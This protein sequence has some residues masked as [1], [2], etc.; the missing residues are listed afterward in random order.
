MTRPDCLGFEGGTKAYDAL[1]RQKAAALFIAVTL[2]KDVL[3]MSGCIRKF[4]FNRQGLADIDSSFEITEPKYGYFELYPLLAKKLRRRVDGMPAIDGRVFRTR[5]YP[6]G[7]R[8][9]DSLVIERRAIV[10]KHIG[11]AIGRPIP[12]YVM[13][14]C[15]DPGIAATVEVTDQ[16]GRIGTATFAR[17]EDR[18]TGE[19]D[20][21][22]S[23]FEPA[24]VIIHRA[25]EEL[26]SCTEQ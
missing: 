4:A 1:H 10:G 6:P 9:D 20:R 5:R 8:G 3:A 7:A 19:I 26:H 12:E 17:D 23:F 22:Q 21:P 2:A 14:V 16:R 15:G 11:P 25:L 18:L 24:F 13:L